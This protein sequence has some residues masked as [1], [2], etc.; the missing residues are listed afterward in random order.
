MDNQKRKS[1]SMTYLQKVLEDFNTFEN[2]RQYT[3]LQGTAIELF[4]FGGFNLKDS[5]KKVVD[6]NSSDFFLTLKEI[7]KPFNK[8]SKTKKYSLFN[9]PQFILSYMNNNNTARIRS[10]SETIDQYFERSMKIFRDFLRNKKTLAPFFKQKPG[11]KVLVI[12]QGIKPI[13]GDDKKPSPKSAEDDPNADF[14]EIE[15][16]SPQ[17]SPPRAPPLRSQGSSS[18]AF[19]SSGSQGSSSALGSASASAFTPPRSQSSSSV[20]DWAQDFPTFVTP[21]GSQ[22]SQGS[23]GP[24]PLSAETQER[25]Q[26]SVSLDEDGVS[27]AKRLLETS[28]EKV[29]SRKTS[30]MSSPGSDSSSRPPSSTTGGRKRKTKKQR[31]L[32]RKTRKQ[33]KQRKLKRKTKK[34]RKLKRKTRKL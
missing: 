14:P 8:T 26:G 15:L 27:S 19:A 9:M 29:S 32:K 10:K 31:K 6:Y 34:Q 12:P 5:Y 20:P 24:V 30:R 17:P 7:F 16:V 2:T 11:K 3:D 21:Q 22:G 1:A 28:F 18:S 23:Q 33:R 13:V 4:Y 25:R